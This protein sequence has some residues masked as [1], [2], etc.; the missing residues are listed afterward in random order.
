MLKQGAGHRGRRRPLGQRLQGA[1]RARAA[2]GRRDR[3]VGDRDD[4]RGR[5]RAVR[6]PR[7]RLPR[8][9]GAPHA[10]HAQRAR[11]RR[12]G[13]AASRSCSSPP[14]TTTGSCRPA[15]AGPRTSAGAIGVSTDAQA[16]W[17][18][19][20]G[21]GTVP[22]G[23]IAAYGGD[24]VRAA[25]RSPTASRR[26]MNV[27]VLV[28]FDNDSVATALE[29]ADALGERPLG[30]AA[31]HLRQ[32]RR[33]VAAAP[34]RRRRAD[35]RRAR[36]RPLTRARARRARLPRRADRRLRRLHRRAHPR[37]RGRRRARRRLRRRLVADPRRQR[38]H[39]RRRDGRRAAGREGR[40]RARPNP[41]LSAVG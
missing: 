31:G 11:G 15:T 16:S 41:R 26:E 33:R 30:R 2:R 17:W 27:T 40:A 29:V 6:P 20:R 5:L 28:D 10:G 21:V 23:L 14:A 32:A 7:D 1:R 34:A 19:G 8:L 3:A 13:A 24:T 25:R 22:H 39:G 38:L 37:V 4:D 12:G 9:H 18:G 36:A 35:G